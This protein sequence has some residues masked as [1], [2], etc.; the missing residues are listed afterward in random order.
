MELNKPVVRL[1][2]ISG[3]EP[4]KFSKVWVLAKDETPYDNIGV[5]EPEKLDNCMA[6]DIPT[7]EYI[8]TTWS[9]EGMPRAFWDQLDRCRLAAF[10]EQ[11]GRVV[12]YSDFAD[13]RHYWTPT[14]ISESPEGLQIYEETMKHL[15]EAYSALVKL[16]IPAEEARGIIPLHVLTRGTMHI[17]LRALKGLIRNRVC[18]VCQGSYWFPVIEGMLKELKQYLPPKT[19]QSLVSLPCAGG[20][21]CPI[22]GNLLQRI[23]GEDPNPVCPVY[24]EYIVKNKEEV[25]TRELQRIP[26]FKEIKERYLKLVDSLGLLKGGG[27]SGDSKKSC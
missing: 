21:H 13:I 12:N 16:G 15:Q 6:T 24:L 4:Y 18:F 20:G 2:D 3:H 7:Q 23:S 10:W 22:E 26:N 9:I 17:N 11:S 5:I 8:T 25:E 27:E 14:R 19:L 1:I